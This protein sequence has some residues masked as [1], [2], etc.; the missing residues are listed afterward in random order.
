M[1]G[2]Q[3]HE[4]INLV[5]DATPRSELADVLSEPSLLGLAACIDPERT[6]TVYTD[7]AEAEQDSGGR[8]FHNA[9][10]TVSG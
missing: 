10:P 5:T 4:R 3:A 8:L 9:G 2:I 6:P 7:R 1:S